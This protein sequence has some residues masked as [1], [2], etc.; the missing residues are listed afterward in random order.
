MN[1]KTFA[2]YSLTEEGKT[3]SATYILGTDV[4]KNSEMLSVSEDS[5]KMDCPHID[6]A[7]ECEEIKSKES[8]EEKV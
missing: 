4:D 8:R 5:G 2:E 3:F 1:E 6:F 7:S